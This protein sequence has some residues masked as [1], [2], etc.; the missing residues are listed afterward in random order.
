MATVSTITGLLLATLSALAAV[1]QASDESYLPPIETQA[2]ALVIPPHGQRTQVA[3]M[4]PGRGTR[5]KYHRIR[6]E[7]WVKLNPGDPSVGVDYAR[8]IGL[9]A[10]EALLVDDTLNN[11]SYRI[12]FYGTDTPQAIEA[13]V[14]EEP[15]RIKGA[16]YLVAT[17][18]APIVDYSG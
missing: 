16:D 15:I 9:Q 7:F 13:D 2:V 11:G 12:G 1:D 14:T 17:V 6:C 18:Y 3:T 8:E 10:I 4:T 5:I